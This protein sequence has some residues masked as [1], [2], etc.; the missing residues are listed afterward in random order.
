MDCYYNNVCTLLQHATF[1]GQLHVYLFK[2][3]LMYSNNAKLAV[4]KEKKKGFSPK[5]DTKFTHCD[6]KVIV[7]S[8]VSISVLVILF[9]YLT[10]E[11]TCILLLLLFDGGR[12][13]HK[14]TSE[15]VMY[16]AGI[17]GVE[18]LLPHY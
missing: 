6:Q 9:F 7:G 2:Y 17:G 4:E 8:F 13:K 12:S 5:M 14:V 3:S 1:N 10:Y 16:V 11:S 18:E 15:L